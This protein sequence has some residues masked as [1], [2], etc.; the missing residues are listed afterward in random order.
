MRDTTERPE[1][2]EAG[3]VK[4]VGTN[5]ET[6]IKE[7]ETLKEVRENPEKP[8]V[9]IIGGVKVDDK[10]PAALALSKVADKVLVGGKIASELK[11]RHDLP[12]NLLLADLTEDQEDI[13]VETV[14]KWTPIISSAHMVL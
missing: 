14:A 10:L 4:L 9:A 3:T 11:N 13:T 12:E 7:V 1:A 5:K 8:L 2:V 6:I